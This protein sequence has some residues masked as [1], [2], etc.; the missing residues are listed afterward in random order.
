MLQLTACYTPALDD[1]RQMARYYHGPRGE[2]AYLAFEHI[3]ATLFDDLLPLPLIQWALTA[4]GG[5]L[6]LTQSS[7]P[8]VITLHPSLLG[9]TQKANPW[10]IDPALLGVCYAYDVLVHECIHVSVAYVQGY[11]RA[12]SETSHNNPVWVSE[13]NRLAPLLG[14]DIRAE[15]SKVKRVKGD[16]GSTRVRRV[17]EA[18]ISFK[19]IATF[20]KRPDFYA[21]GVLPFE[22]ATPAAA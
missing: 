18:S 5:C 8:P 2:F 21:R 7:G 15:Q 20:P 9:G 6:G 19:D 12:K 17:C 10:G 13:V 14:L 1:L 16:D 11:H 4:H 3:N 22:A